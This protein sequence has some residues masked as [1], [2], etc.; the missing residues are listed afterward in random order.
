MVPSPEFNV[1]ALFRSPKNKILSLV[2]LK[3]SLEM[4]NNPNFQSLLMFVCEKSKNILF[5][6]R[7]KL[8]FF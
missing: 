5:S 2:P 1:S 7:K 8:M 4:L 6:Y 3:D